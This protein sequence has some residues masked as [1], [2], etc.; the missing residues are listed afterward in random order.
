MEV[1]I[2]VL[3]EPVPL[4]VGPPTVLL[5]TGYG[6]VDGAALGKGAAAEPVENGLP[7]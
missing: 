6:A 2:V 5:P 3:I 1:V 7:E 4:P